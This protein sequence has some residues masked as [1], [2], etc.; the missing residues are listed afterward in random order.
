MMSWGCIPLIPELACPQIRAQ[1]TSPSLPPT[2]PFFPLAT[3]QGIYLLSR[4]R[5][6]D[7]EGGRAIGAAS[8]GMVRGCPKQQPAAQSHRF[9][10]RIPSTDQHGRRSSNRSSP[11]TSDSSC[12]DGNPQPSPNF[13]LTMDTMHR[14]QHF[15]TLAAMGPELAVKFGGFPL[16]LGSLWPPA[17]VSGQKGS[18]A[19]ALLPQKTKWDPSWVSYVTKLSAK[20][21]PSAPLTIEDHAGVGVS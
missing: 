15:S 21:A 14:A 9:A 10:V 13:A 6:R 12:V 17:H 20:P 16:S 8:S 4:S 7:L 5:K 11:G 2:P 19:N 1:R 3:G 18:P